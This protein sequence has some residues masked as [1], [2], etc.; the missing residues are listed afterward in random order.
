MALLGETQLENTKWHSHPEKGLVEELAQQNVAERSQKEAKK[1]K[2]Q[3]GRRL[4]L[5]C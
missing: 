5:C 4:S 2:V 3:D 1:S